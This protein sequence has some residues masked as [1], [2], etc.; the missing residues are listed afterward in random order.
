MCD[1]TADGRRFGR[2]MELAQVHAP[3][4]GD[5]RLLQRFVFADETEYALLEQSVNA[6][7]GEVA[8]EHQQPRLR[9]RTL[10]AAHRLRGINTWQRVVE[11][12]DRSLAADI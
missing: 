10:K 5:Q 3:D 2:E 9:R 1:L 11:Q 8:S 6:G 7:G 12:H 4:T